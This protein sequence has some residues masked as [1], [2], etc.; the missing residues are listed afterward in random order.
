MDGPLIS[1]VMPCYKMGQFIAEA[2]ESVGKQSYTNWEVIAVDDCGPEDG[3]R[4]IVE[5][6]AQRHTRHRVEFI[7]HPENRRLGATRNTA[8]EAALGKLIAFLD[9]D[10]YWLP[11]HLEAHILARETDPE[12]D[13]SG[14]SMRV[15]L[16]DGITGWPQV[17]GYSAWE[18]SYFPATL[19]LR[20][21]INPSAVVINRNTFLKAGGFD[22]SPEL[23]MVEDYDL[24][25]R[26]QR[27]RAKFYILPEITGV[28]RKH[29]G[30][31]TAPSQKEA[32]Q[33]R[34]EALA[35][36]HYKQWLPSLAFSTYCLSERV[37]HLENRVKWIEKSLAFRVEA[38]VRRFMKKLL[39]LVR[40]RD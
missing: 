33:Q 27:N 29:E 35:A 40:T 19:S 37:G 8:V 21:A 28:Y 7:R 18:A 26:L 1:V 10:D 22:T 39:Q 34:S 24:W 5:K 9:P 31:A 36:K 17:W 32:S 13:V 25:F 14:S 23:H 3:T 38:G 6:F 16:E 11:N 15:L 20:S 12:I 30:A 4:E 2:L